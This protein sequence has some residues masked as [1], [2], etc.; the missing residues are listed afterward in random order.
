MDLIK[1]EIELPKE[2][3]ELADGA[4]NLVVAVAAALKDGFDLGQDLPTI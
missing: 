1:K 4:A 3:S 2:T